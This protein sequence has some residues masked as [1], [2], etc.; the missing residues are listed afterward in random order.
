M[1]A[2]RLRHE[3]GVEP[4]R[5]GLWSPGRHRDFASREM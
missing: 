3:G 5:P 2:T 4:P 1:L